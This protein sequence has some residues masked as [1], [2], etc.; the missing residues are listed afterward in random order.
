MLSALNSSHTDKRAE[1]LTETRFK[2]TSVQVAFR[3]HHPKL[4]S[5]DPEHSH[6]VLY[7]RIEW[8]QFRSYWK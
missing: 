4:Q 6:A 8:E 1:K 3:I 7:G 5:K 2:I